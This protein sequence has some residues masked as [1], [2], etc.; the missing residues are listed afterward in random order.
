M[1]T[2]LL[3]RQ[4]PGSCGACFLRLCKAAGIRQ[5]YR[6]YD[7]GLLELETCPK[8]GTTYIVVPLTPV[9]ALGGAHR[10]WENVS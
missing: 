10:L 2:E 7:L 4:V 8:P 1:T 9:S 5:L 6:L 3:E